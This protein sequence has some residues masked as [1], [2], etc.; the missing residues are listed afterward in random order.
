[1]G[2]LLSD[3]RGGIHAYPYMYIYTYP[4]YTH[5]HMHTFYLPAY[6]PKHT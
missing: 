6:I 3:G 1:M 4:T 2:E 5:T